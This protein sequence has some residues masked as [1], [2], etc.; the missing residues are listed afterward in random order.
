[1]STIRDAHID[2]HNDACFE[3]ILSGI[4]EIT[5]EFPPSEWHHRITFLF[6]AAWV[7]KAKKE[8]AIE[9]TTVLADFA[10]RAFLRIVEMERK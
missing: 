5:C 4:R 7:E 2:E 9:S 10:A 1:M 8:G 3:Q 6:A